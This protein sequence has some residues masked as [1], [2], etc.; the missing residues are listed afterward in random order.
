MKVSRVDG[1]QSEKEMCRLLMFVYSSEYSIA[2]ADSRSG[3]FEVFNV[4]CVE[5]WKG[6]YI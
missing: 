1:V 6:I 5:K 4:L 3:S 2:Y